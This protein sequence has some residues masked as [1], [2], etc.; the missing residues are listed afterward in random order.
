MPRRSQGPR[1]YLDKRRRQ[2]VIRDGTH[3]ERTGCAEGD[4]SSAE[5]KLEQ[6]IG[7]KH[8]TKR[9][10]SPP[11]ADVLLAYTRDHGAHQASGEN[12]LHTVSNLEKWWG[13]KMLSDVT[14]ANCRAYIA[15]RPKYAA[16]RDLETLRAAIRF[17][18]QEY[19]PLA[20]VPKVT[21][22]PRAPARTRWLTRGEVAALLWHS[23]RVPHLA[24]FI[25]LAV[26]T[27]SRSGAVLGLTWSRIDLVRGLMLRREEGEIDHANKRRPP[28]RLGRKI[29]G[30]LKRW[31]K[32]DA[33]SSEWVCHYSGARVTKL[34]RS[35]ARARTAAK[36]DRHVT[37]H[38][39]RH[40]RATWMMQAGINPFEAA[41]ALGMSMRVLESTYGHHHP[42]YQSNAAEV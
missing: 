38:T 24:R 17:W 30:H 35:F 32:K 42:D 14:A 16:R 34:R 1:L 15:A 40:T 31:K 36:L 8:T 37:P 33:G 3:F 2:W 29:L 23:R 19:G 9:S 39:L 26:Y 27:G 18:D 12:I 25:L 6:Y 11:L 4:R 28:V 7:R 41:G 21:L 22:P 5:K 20:F 13:D 10:P